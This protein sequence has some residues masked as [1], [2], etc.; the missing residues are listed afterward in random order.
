MQTVKKIQSST[1]YD[2]QGFDESPFHSVVYA[3]A[4]DYLNDLFIVSQGVLS[5]PLY[6][7]AV[8]KIEQHEKAGGTTLDFQLT[9]SEIRTNH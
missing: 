3:K 6:V 1:V 8:D 9:I 4:S 2:A 5:D 7:I